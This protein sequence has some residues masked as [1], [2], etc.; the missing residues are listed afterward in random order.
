LGAE[1]RKR[2]LGEGWH[3][4]R[5]SEIHP[6]QAA[7][8]PHR[9]GLGLEPFLEGRVGNVGRI[10][11]GAVNRELPAVIDATNATGFDASQRQ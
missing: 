2:P 10:E 7:R 4:R 11:Y 6:D 9:I 1:D 8:L 3:L 5:R